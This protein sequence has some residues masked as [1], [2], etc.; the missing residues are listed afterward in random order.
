LIHQILKEKFGFDSFRGDQEEII[1]T[2]ISKKDAL[3]LMPTGGGKSL[4]YQI[5]ALCMEGVT[6]VISPLISLM[7][8]QVSALKLNGIKAES[9]NSSQS[10]EKY[11]EITQQ[12]RDG[13]LDLLY[14]SP[15]GLNT[16]T[17]WN[18]LDSIKISLFAIDE[19]HCVSQ[20]GHD[21]R[22]DYL[23]L[24][25]IRERY[26]ETPII[27][28]TAT[29]DLQ[30]REDI[31][32]QLNLR[33]YSLYTSSFNRENIFYKMAPKRNAYSQVKDVVLQ[34]KGECG[35]IYCP[36]VKKVESLCSKLQGE[37][38]NVIQYHG[39]MDNEER[40]LNLKRFEQE[41]DVIVVA[42]IAFGMGI[43]KPNVRFVCHN[44]MSKNLENFYQESGR[45]GRDGDKSFSYVY[46]GL[47]DLMT[48]KRFIDQ[49]QMNETHK[50]NAH[51]K[52]SFMYKFCESEDCKTNIIL[53]YFGEIRDEEC[54]HCDS[55]LDE[56]QRHE[57]TVEAQKF[58]SCVYRLNNRFGASYV[59]DV[60]RAAKSKRI[61]DF[62]HDKLSVHGIG[63]D[64]SKSDWLS[65][66]EKLLSVGYL[67]IETEYKTLS[68]TGL[69]VKVLKEGE[70][71]FIRREIK[72]EGAK[73]IKK[74]G[75]KQTSEIDYD[76]DLL[77]ELKK[78][79]LAMAKELS[80]AS[81]MIASNA[82]LINLAAVKPKTKDDLLLVNGIG[83]KK[84]E[85]FGED[86][87]NII[88]L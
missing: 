53:K 60:L 4:C 59:I 19:A 38:F 81:Y 20:W 30:V 16:N 48:Y 63:K 7:Q 32:R 46:Y 61:T 50:K 87:L 79:R 34:H 41:D 83:K 17:A 64:L 72:K 71:V 56:Y 1:K 40:S 62:G 70:K 84:A 26:S 5:P 12:L 43:D 75:S 45:A 31:A 35:I 73:R 78:Y 22:K 25:S 8:N 24:S 68:L 58:L 57:V 9:L 33:N 65:I 13:E 80:V 37:G 15:E 39:Q 51:D 67:K 74:L 49:S 55:C 27:A 76:E 28:L 69:A 54:G 47:D 6:I 85:E 11:R 18:L 52:I 42:T 82:T 2:L 77:S 86:F 21:F 36:T 44:G 66:N 88:N 29:A 3:V 10:S 14:L 23:N